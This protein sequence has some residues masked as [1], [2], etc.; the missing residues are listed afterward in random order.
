MLSMYFTSIKM[1]F[2]LSIPK[3]LSSDSYWYALYGTAWIKPSRLAKACGLF[4]V[5]PNAFSTYS[6]SATAS[7]IRTSILNSRN[8]AITDGT[9]LL[10]RSGIFS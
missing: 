9:M 1:P 2:N 8:V 3:R 4:R 5:S 7:W 6:G 10:R